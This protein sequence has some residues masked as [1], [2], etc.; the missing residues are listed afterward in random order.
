MLT[1]LSTALSSLSLVIVLGL[2]VY[3]SCM[4]VTRWQV[5]CSR[6]L[7]SRH[8]SDVFSVQS[9]LKIPEA[10]AHWISSNPWLKGVHAVVGCLQI[11]GWDVKVQ[12]GTFWD[13]Q[14]ATPARM[15]FCLGGLLDLLR[16]GQR[17]WVPGLRWQV[18]ACSQR[19]PK[20]L[21]DCSPL[22]LGTFTC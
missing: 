12:W 10:K 2:N 1:I 15:T 18:R 20:E 4:F 14:K 7:L 19:G 6:S 11:A 17:P 22:P 13:R 3:T 21:E 9:M 5:L 16:Q 8:L